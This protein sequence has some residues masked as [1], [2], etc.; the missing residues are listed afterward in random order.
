[1]V[2]F[3]KSSDEMPCVFNYRFPKGRVL[4]K[5]A[6]LRHRGPKQNADPDLAKHYAH[7]DVQNQQVK[8]FHFIPYKICKYL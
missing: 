3:G 7:P 2:V 5:S 4:E 1:M 8:A 6:Y